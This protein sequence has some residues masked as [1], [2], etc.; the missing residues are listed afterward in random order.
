MVWWLTG[1][2]WASRERLVLSR[3]VW[4]GMAGVLGGLLL[5]ELA[6]GF[7][8]LGD[9]LVCS[10]CLRSA[11]NMP[12]CYVSSSGLTPLTVECI[13]EWLPPVSILNFWYNS[14]TSSTV[15]GFFS[16]T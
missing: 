14:Q 6:H 1:V 8:Q 4:C 12:V 2:C 11:A 13:D 9:L 7:S 15:P 16:L 3:K 10:V 5:H